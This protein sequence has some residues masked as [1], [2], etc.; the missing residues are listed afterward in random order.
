LEAQ[1]ET[2]FKKWLSL[3]LVTILIVSM[4]PEYVGLAYSDS[5]ESQEQQT[6]SEKETISTDN[7]KEL[8]DKRTAT[9][10]TFTDRKLLQRNL[11]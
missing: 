6:D 10:K 3:F 9:T 1:N 4:I 5:K 7:L 2:I 11:C 8:K